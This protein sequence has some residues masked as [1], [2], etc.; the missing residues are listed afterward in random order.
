MPGLTPYTGTIDIHAANGQEIAAF[1][2]GTFPGS[3]SLAFVN[4]SAVSVSVSSISILGTN[5]SNF[6]VSTNAVLPITIANVANAG[7]LPFNIVFT[8]AQP[9]ADG[10]LLA[11]PISA[12]VGFGNTV[13]NG[14]SINTTP[15]TLNSTIATV[16]G[17]GGWE[18]CGD[19]PRIWASNAEFCRMRLLGYV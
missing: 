1:Q 18:G 9:N 16:S 12:A 8:N 5:T 19:T 6:T 4:V 3:A 7:S 15:Q 2:T 10:T 14:V 17:D 13:Q 11:L